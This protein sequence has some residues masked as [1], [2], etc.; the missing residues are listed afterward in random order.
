MDESKPK[1]R[2]LAM[3]NRLRSRQKKE[4]DKSKGHLVKSH[5]SSG[6]QV[7]QIR[8]NGK[9]GSTQTMMARSRTFE[10]QIEILPRSPSH[11][12][13]LQNE[14][15]KLRARPLIK[16]TSADRQEDRS[17]AIGYGHSQLPSPTKDRASAM[18]RSRSVDTGEKP[19]NS[20]VNNT[21]RHREAREG[22]YG[23]HGNKGDVEG[24]YGRHGKTQDGEKCVRSPW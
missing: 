1:S 20:L 12:K 18:A 24:V 3:K 23:H 15:S 17:R 14:K 22:V 16:S 13:T 4:E 11:G 5:S 19:H 10:G 2:L 8:A 21:T 6:I 9:V 7:D